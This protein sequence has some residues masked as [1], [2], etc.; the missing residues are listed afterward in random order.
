MGLVGRMLPEVVDIALQALV[1]AESLTETYDLNSTLL[2]DQ[3]NG[4][5]KKRF[6]KV[7]NSISSCV[8]IVI[9]AL[10]IEPF[11]FLTM[12]Y[13][14]HGYRSKVGSKKRPSSAHP[15]TSFQ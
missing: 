1:F 6:F 4:K 11:R 15:M 12:W 9:Q 10:V 14:K 13:L 8:I 7:F 2:W 3:V 5:G